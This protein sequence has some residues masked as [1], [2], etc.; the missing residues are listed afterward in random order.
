MVTYIALLRGINVGG[1]NLIKMDALRG[2]CGKLKLR[3]VATYVQSGNVVF[4]CAECDPAK[5]AARL[6][7]AIEKEF[8]VRPAVIL[9]TAAELR[10]IVSRNP[11]A[12]RTDVEPG[13]LLVTFFAAPPPGSLTGLPQCPEEFHL[14]GREMF[15]HYPNG[16]GK[17]S[18][19][20]VKLDRAL[21]L[22]G[23]ARNW[24]TVSKL[25][26]MCGKL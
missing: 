14:D 23:T 20:L 21:G 18:I 5:L 7:T 6:E 16:A 2:L 11:F 19:P 4:R 13:K 10:G 3:D 22:Q 17:A 26:E 9:R 15:T 12:G 1:H 25:L 8:G 24:N